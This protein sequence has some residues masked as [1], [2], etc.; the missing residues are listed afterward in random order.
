MQNKCF[1]KSHIIKIRK[2]PLP[3][4]QKQNTQIVGDDDEDDGDRNILDHCV[5]TLQLNIYQ[6]Q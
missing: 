3:S 2:Q 1:N 4:P 6:M 5:C